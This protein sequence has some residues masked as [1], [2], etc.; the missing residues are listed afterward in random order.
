MPCFPMSGSITNE[1][2]AL[3]ERIALFANT[4]DVALSHSPSWLVHHVVHHQSNML[5][6]GIR[7]EPLA[8]GVQPLE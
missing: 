4:I 1:G 8:P 2:V 5:W 3:D 6:W 7:V